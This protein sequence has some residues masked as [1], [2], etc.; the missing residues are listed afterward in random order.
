[1]CQGIVI[2]HEDTVALFQSDT[3]PGT[4]LCLRRWLALLADNGAQ[5]FA[6]AFPLL[7]GGELAGWCEGKMLKGCRDA[8]IWVSEGV[9]GPFQ[10]QCGTKAAWWL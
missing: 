4:G 8:V 2:L 10:Y 6:P 9:G 1:M 7:P 5:G 3:S